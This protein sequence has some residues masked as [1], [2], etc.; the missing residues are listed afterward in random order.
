MGSKRTPLRP[1]G[2]VVFGPK[3][4]DWSV[5]INRKERQLALSTALQSAAPDALVVD[6]LA[7]AVTGVPRTAAF[8]A[9]LRRWGF[10]PGGRQAALLFLAD[11]E[12]S[13]ALRLSSRNIPR[14]T[15]ATPRSLN[16]YDVLR[17]DKLILTRAG[18]E[19]LNDMYGEPGFAEFEA[20]ADDGPP[21]DDV[22]DGANDG[23]ESG[24]VGASF[25]A[26]QASAEDVG[27]APVDSGVVGEAAEP[28]VA[29][30]AGVEAAGAPA[31]AEPEADAA[32][33]AEA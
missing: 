20:L 25:E 21:L 9:A 5:K 28:E 19:Y 16:L 30:E 24:V 31:E 18:L 12:L 10:V 8:A 7:A 6:G 23:Y 27:S 22:V 2:G 14:L 26:A 3:P 15:V 1:G 13:D 4:K 32:A 17:A 29:S 33:E 11:G